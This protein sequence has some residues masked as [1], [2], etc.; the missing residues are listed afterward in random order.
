MFRFVLFL[1]FLLHETQQDDKPDPVRWA[2][3]NHE[4]HMS[5]GVTRLVQENLFPTKR[6]S[7]AYDIY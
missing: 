6:V 1:P 3:T 2:P 4:Y 7:Q 5:E